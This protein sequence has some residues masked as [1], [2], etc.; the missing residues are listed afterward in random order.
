MKKPILQLLSALTRTL[1]LFQD[2]NHPYIDDT[3]MTTITHNRRSSGPTD[4]VTNADSS[5][6][7][8]CHFINPLKAATY[9]RSLLGVIT[10]GSVDLDNLSRFCS[11]ACKEHLQDLYACQSSADSMNVHGESYND[12]R[13]DLDCLMAECEREISKHRIPLPKHLW[14]RVTA[15]KNKASE[16][17]GSLQRTLEMSQTLLSDY[18]RQLEKLVSQAVQ[19]QHRRGR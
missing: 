12:A 18:S 5:P 13:K 19:D 15:A 4:Q 17:L 8:S 9:F 16:E 6:A 14:D 3:T 10:Y 1:H 7:P 2:L 11:D